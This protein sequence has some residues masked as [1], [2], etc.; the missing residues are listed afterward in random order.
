MGLRLILTSVVYVSQNGWRMWMGPKCL[1]IIRSR[2]LYLIGIT[3]I[4]DHDQKLATKNNRKQQ[5]DKIEET[6][7]GICLKNEE[8]MDHA[9]EVN[10]IHWKFLA[11]VVDRILH[12]LHNILICTNIGVLV[13]RLSADWEL[14]KSPAV[15][16]KNILYA[17]HFIWLW[18]DKLWYLINTLP[19]SAVKLATRISNRV[20]VIDYNGW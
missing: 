14:W 7:S 4:T 11:L 5:F 17:R 8:S 20:Y 16:Y 9:K 10:N 2:G 6:V 12:I 19:P 15:L 18:D 1:R 3:P 13:W